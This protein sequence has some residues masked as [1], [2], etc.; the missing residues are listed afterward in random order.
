MARFRAVVELLAACAAVAGCAAS[1]SAG[2]N[3]ALAVAASAKLITRSRNPGAIC[4]RVWRAA[5]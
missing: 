4:G 2:A 3:C 5:R 1:W